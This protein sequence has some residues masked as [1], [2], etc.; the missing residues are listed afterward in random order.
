M[1]RTTFV[2]HSLA[3]ATAASA[4]VL[5]APAAVA[6]EPACGI[7]ATEAVW[8]TVVTEP[9]YRTVEEVAHDEW[10][11]EREVLTEE[12]R[13]VAGLPEQ[14]HFETVV[15]ASAVVAIEDEYLHQTTGRVRWER[16]DWG[17]QN[18]VGQGWIKTGASRETVISPEETEQRWVVDV[19]A[20]PAST[21]RS[22]KSSYE[23]TAATS[24]AA[25]EGE[26]WTAIEESRV[27]VVDVPAYDEL[28][29]PGSEE[30]VLISAAT[31]GT[32][33]CEEIAIIS[34]GGPRDETAADS[35]AGPQAAPAPTAGALPAAA[36]PPVVLPNTGGV[37]GW[38]TPVGG[39]SALA[40]IGLV[41][42]ARRRA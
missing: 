6:D 37:A 33:P 9:T 29:A 12:L 1:F 15:L 35:V 13:D 19:P 36:T 27:R 38:M 31:P 10:R 24:A 28:V 3:A 21:E 4:I 16:S 30:Q 7:P 41:L 22:R 8:K 5:T 14:G 26:G 34:D 40:G 2:K 17:A 39:G 25:P 42:A 20:V 11:W 23:S 32:E 18:G